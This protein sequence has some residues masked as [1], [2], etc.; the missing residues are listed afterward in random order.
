M[1]S[2]VSADSILFTGGSDSNICI[3]SQIKECFFGLPPS[4]SPPSGSGPAIVDSKRICSLNIS[5]D[6]VLQ[7]LNNGGNITFEKEEFIEF[8]QKIISETKI[9]ITSGSL[10]EVIEDC[11][12][13]KEGKFK[14]FLFFL[15]IMLFITGLVFLTYHNR[16][17]AFIVVLI[18]RFNKMRKK[19]VIK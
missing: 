12:F 8:R 16:K 6:F 2:L 15:F 1:I 10:L 19:L 11:G 18:D 5:K 7:H 14:P 4:V 17:K 13:V 3:N 9:P